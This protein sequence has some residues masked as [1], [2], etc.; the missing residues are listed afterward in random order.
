MRQSRRGVCLV[1]FVSRSLESQGKKMPRERTRVLMI[2]K[3]MF[4][5]YGHR[6][7]KEGPSGCRT[8]TDS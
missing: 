5:W 7:T 6:L 2:R 3:P 1:G 8:G 4:P